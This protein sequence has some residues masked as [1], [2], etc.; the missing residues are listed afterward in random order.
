MS[1]QQSRTSE[2]RGIARRFWS[3]IVA[4]RV[5]ILL[6][7]L[8]LLSYAYFFPRW[9]EWNQNSR[10]DLTMAIVD[11]CTVRIDDYHE[12]TGDYALFE[13]HYYTEKSIGPSLLA[14]PFYAAFRGVATTPLW[15]RFVELARSNE[16]FSATLQEGGTGLLSEKIYFAAALYVVTFFTVSVP[17][18]IL[19]VLFYRFLR[20]F[21][22]NAG[23]RLLLVLVFG[24]GTN[25]FTYSGLFYHHPQSTI[26]LFLSFILLFK[27][28]RSEVGWKWLWV[29]GLL[30]SFSL[31]SEYSTILIVSALFVYT[32]LLMPDKR[33]IALLVAGG[34]PLVLV[35]F[36]Y[37]YISFRTPLPVGYLYDPNYTELHHTGLVTVTYPKLDI[38]W[39]ITFSPYRGLFFV[40]P[41]LLLG[42]PGFFYFW[43]ERRY[44]P[45]FWVCLTSV[46][47]FFL[48]NSASVVW[49]GGY[50]VGPRYIIPMLPFLTLS[51]IFFLDRKGDAA[52]VRGLAYLLAIVS[53]LVVWIETISGQSLPD[54]TPNPLFNYSL[55][56]LISGDIAR[57]VGMVLGLSRWYS[58]IPLGV[59]MTVIGF[60][61]VRFVSGPAKSDLLEGVR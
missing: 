39:Q 13:G 30:W 55:P 58:L 17:A 51:I 18:A 25:W 42:A 43:R 34:A 50:A 26:A 46:V 36:A 2:R 16:A 6:F 10:L 33:K 44:R 37:N 20:Y 5:E 56:R 54:F 23:W 60:F 35:F 27:M 59:M 1:N 31:I 15:S 61:L 7:L 29:V 24:L 3:A 28:R 48:I 22:S 52:W 38:L 12:N 14:I 41:F 57:N 21:S 45:E 53:G 40:S 47:S 4:R 9:A 11:Q 19:S 8:S 32:M 49:W